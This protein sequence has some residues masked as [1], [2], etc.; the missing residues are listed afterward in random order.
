M[1]EN[2]NGDICY[3]VVYGSTQLHCQEGA[4]RNESAQVE[5][6]PRLL[7]TKIKAG[8][9]AEMAKNAKVRKKEWSTVVKRSTEEA[10]DSVI[11]IEDEDK[12]GGTN[13]GSEDRSLRAMPRLSRYVNEVE[14]NVIALVAAAAHHIDNFDEIAV[15]SLA[16]AKDTIGI[17]RGLRGSVN[18]AVR[19][20]LEG[21]YG[22]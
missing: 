5:F 11:T 12:K 8:P 7:S 1:V 20:A 15:K 18:K 14:M 22:R 4:D 19:K 2:R 9:V 10:E 16:L 17:I 6:G 21:S 3:A 13:E